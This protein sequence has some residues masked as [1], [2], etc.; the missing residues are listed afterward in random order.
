VTTLRM[1]KHH[2]LGND[3]LVLVDLEG[4]W[5]LSPG[6]VAR[7]CD[8]RRG[9]GADG[10]IRV[11]AGNDGCDLSMELRNADGEEAEVSGNGIRCLAQAALY[12]GLISGPDLVV[13]TAAGPRGVHVSPTGRPEVARVRV[14]MGLPAVGPA[15]EEVAV[16]DRRWLG[17]SVR[18]GNP[19]LVLVEGDL[20]SLDLGVLGPALQARQTGGINVEWAHPG[21]GRDALTI[22]VWERGVGETL[23]C[24]SGSVAAA[25]A[26]RAMGLVAGR[27]LTVHNPG[28]DLQV[29]WSC[30]EAYLEGPAER[31]G[32][33]EVEV[34]PSP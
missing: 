24:G 4:H 32:V 10:L 27:R 1:A 30:E 28:G 9:M 22:R 26:A 20:G 6:T 11:L 3:F 21:P 16:A 15:D 12:D 29:E 13:G 33:V 18:V 14:G 2:G 17:R 23:A 19:H 8:R 7:L 34:G 25:A 5:P 31:L